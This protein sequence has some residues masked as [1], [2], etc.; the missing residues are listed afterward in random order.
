MCF[1]SEKFNALNIIMHVQQLTAFLT[2]HFFFS[3][4]NINQKNS[5]HRVNIQRE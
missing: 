4:S 3:P 1:E 2:T 5:T